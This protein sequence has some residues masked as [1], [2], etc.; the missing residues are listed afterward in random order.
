MNNNIFTYFIIPALVIITIIITRY[1]RNK[2]YK[3]KYEN[4]VQKP[5]KFQI[6]LVNFLVFLDGILLFFAVMGIM[7]KE[8]EMA[9][10]FGGLALFFLVVILFLKRAYD[11][12]YQENDEY[13][14][15]KTKNKEHKVF[16]ENIID[17]QPSF[18][19]IAIL[20]KT[21]PDKKYIRVNI[22]LFKPEILLLEIADMAFDGKFNNLDQ[23]HTEDQN[24]EVE[25]VYYLV[26]N[27]YGYLVED[28]VKKIENKST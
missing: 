20:D 27:Q 10:A 26:D 14:I 8:T 24:R 3:P 23:T 11:I 7:M 12:S 28:Y 25:T 4:N 2:I 13:F 17:W 19:E 5:G 6:F 1:V 9:L 15:L 18:N 16:Y 22:R 21:K